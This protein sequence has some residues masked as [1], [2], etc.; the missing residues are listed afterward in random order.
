MACA[1]AVGG[2]VG[3]KPRLPV[4]FGNWQ[5]VCADEILVAHK[6]VN[7][8]GGYWQEGQIDNIRKQLELCRTT[9]D[10]GWKKHAE[11]QDLLQH[12]QVW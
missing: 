11:K 4:S 12:D 3:L 2:A 8:H 6:H 10:G 5:H 7:L 1:A 9:P